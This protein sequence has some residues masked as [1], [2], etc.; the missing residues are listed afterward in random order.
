[1]AFGIH[2]CAILYLHTDDTL[3]MM[4]PNTVFNNNV[5]C[6]DDVNTTNSSTTNSG[7][8]VLGGSHVNSTCDGSLCGTR[9]T[10]RGNCHDDDSHGKMRLLSSTDSGVFQWEGNDSRPDSLFVTPQSSSANKAEMDHPKQGGVSS[11]CSIGCSSTIPKATPSPPKTAFM[12]FSIA[13]TK[14]SNATKS[15][16]YDSL[17][18]EYK[19]LPLSEKKK[20][21][22]EA[23]KD[24][25][26]YTDE[27]NGH[28]GPWQLPI[29]RAK[30]HPL[31]PKR[32]MSAFLRYSKSLRQKVKHE[33]PHVDNTDISRLLGHMWRNA[34][35]EEKEPY[36]KQELKERS[37]YKVEMAKWRM[38]QKK[39][40]IEMALNNSPLRHQNHEIESPDVTNGRVH[41]NVVGACGDFQ[42]PQQYNPPELKG[43]ESHYYENY[44]HNHSGYT[45]APYYNSYGGSQDPYEDYHH[46]HHN[47]N[48]IRRNEQ[49]Y[50]YDE[51]SH[52]EHGSVVDSEGCYD[53]TY[54]S[55]DFHRRYHYEEKSVAS[56]NDLRGHHGGYHVDRAYPRYPVQNDH[57]HDDATKRRHSQYYWDRSDMRECHEPPY[58]SR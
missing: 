54:R 56:E 45:P 10:L 47:K 44:Y 8:G 43:R 31:A 29:R 46:Q 13:R 21:E 58:Y 7:L 24:K 51:P 55:H 3:K 41:S 14:G 32:P 39:M 16:D 57:E 33:N 34:S 25:Q 5:K 50:K 17:A 40:E 22:V 53:K 30:K 6:D 4:S 9:E 15:L 28:Q 20:W 35:A 49:Y 48:D 52:Y 1:M 42:T 27:K 18:E 38:I 36:L 2:V 12:C 37:I 26:R 23:Q 11:D 19:R